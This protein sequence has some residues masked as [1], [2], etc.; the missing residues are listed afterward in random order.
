MGVGAHSVGG[1]GGGGVG[2]RSGMCLRGGMLGPLSAG[3][4][5]QG[6]GGA[7]GVPL[8]L[9]PCWLLAGDRMRMG[10]VVFGVAGFLCGSGSAPCA[11]VRCQGVV[12]A[13]C[14]PPLYSWGRARLRS[15][16][17]THGVPGNLW[18][19]GVV[20]GVIVPPVWKDAFV[21]GSVACRHSMV[22]ERP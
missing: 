12:L 11:G 21:A 13:G 17:V 20:V 5:C 4:V 18:P 9:L 10:R 2:R 15:R 6:A 7:P 14:P 22:P 16:Q 8:L 1:P 19:R 3:Q